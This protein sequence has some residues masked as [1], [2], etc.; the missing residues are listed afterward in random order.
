MPGSEGQD[1]ARAD[2]DVQLKTSFAG[3]RVLLAEDDD[4]NREIGTM[5][6]EDVGLAVDVAEDGQA[7]LEMATSKTYDLI[8]MDM[9]MPK[10]DGME[11]T[12]QIRSSGHALP[13]VAMTANAFAEDRQRCL[14]AGMDDFL[15]KPV[16][17]KVFYQVLLRQL[18]RRKV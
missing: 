11:A 5:L 14:E 2:A 12:R 15:T 7:A 1:E 6:L 3:R 13:I 16:D 4:F 9:Q 8:L 10:M 18:S 17:P